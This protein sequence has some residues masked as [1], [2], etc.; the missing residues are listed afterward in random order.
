MRKN[1]KLKEKILEYK[2]QGSVVHFNEEPFAISI[3]TALMRRESNLETA[4]DL[5]FVDSTSSCDAENHSIS[6]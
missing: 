2:K 4:A 1:T 6:L 3:V 5:V